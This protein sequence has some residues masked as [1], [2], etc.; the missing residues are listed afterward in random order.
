MGDRDSLQQQADKII[1]EIYISE[2][3]SMLRMA[4][5]VLESRSLGEVAVQE[6]FVIALRKRESLLESVS[7]VGWVYKTLKFIIRD[8]LKEKQATL[9]RFA[10]D[11][12]INT[13][14]YHEDNSDSAISDD[15]KTSKEMR[16]LYEFYI[17]GYSI[18]ELA[19][20][21][22]ITE[23]AMKMRLYRSRKKLADKLK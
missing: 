11:T 5:T 7:P 4:Q 14:T 13:I 15:I 16:L 1:Q 20:K 12:D 23:D 3:A 9:R 10:L 2:Y 17:I 18:R 21:Y 6:T 8:M 22:A 19:E